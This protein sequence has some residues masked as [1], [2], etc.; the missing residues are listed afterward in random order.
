M[1]TVRHLR[2]LPFLLLVSAGCIGGSP[3]QAGNGPSIVKTA[4]APPAPTYNIHL[5]ALENRTMVLM[6]HDFVKVR[7]RASLWYD[8]SE[9]ELRKQIAFV[10][11]NGGTFVSL[12]DLHNHLTKGV[13][14]PPKPVV[15][16]ADDN[17]QGV[18]D[19]AVPVFREFNIPYSNFVPTGFVGNLQGRPKMTW[20]TL[21]ELLKDPLCTIGSHTITH[22]A[23]I[24]LLDY[25]TQKKELEDSKKD[26]ESN[27]GIKIK[28]LAYP[29]GKN[30][31]NVQELSREAGY[32]LAVSTN[33][34]T[35]ETSPNVLSVNRYEQ[36][37]LERHWPERET[38]LSNAVLSTSVDAIKPS[39]VTVIQDKFAGVKLTLIAGG[40]PKSVLA[41]GRQTVS[42]FMASEPGAVAGINGGFFSMAAIASTDNKMV[43]PCYPGNVRSFFN[44]PEDARLQKLINRPIIFW[45]G[46][47]LGIAPFQPA[48]M[49]V[50]DPYLQ[51]M[52]KL[53]DLFLGGVWMVHDGVALSREQLET[54]GAKDIMDYRR[55]AFFG[56]DKEG[57]VVG[58]ASM[59]SYRTDQVAAAA[60][61]AGVKEA[62]LLDSGFSTSL[63]FGDAI[64]ASGHSSPTNP[65]RPVPHAI[66][67]L[68]EKDPAAKFEVIASPNEPRKRRR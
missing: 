10:Q 68:G 31:F 11:S 44:D 60:A 16:T 8:C 14:L 46:E 54:Y 64:I 52:P 9:E 12:D 35:A 67:F 45:D 66:V 62:V 50:I 24:T 23:D 28:Y 5:K 13:P 57:R 3:S 1:V 21:K 56:I 19:I 18:Y 37:T 47:Q 33:P 34:G 6:Y 27:L 36:S 51:L 32:L 53:T 26:L 41:E 49:N 7:D 59:G 15:M 25:A 20:D 55:R 61:E 48:S 4:E 2:L 58:G 38:I 39:P 43:G 30:D 65:S 63:V 29:D 17:Y 40:T 42:E 22:P